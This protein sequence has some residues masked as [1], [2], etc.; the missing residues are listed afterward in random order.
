MRVLQS[1][2]VEAAMVQNVEDIKNDPQLKHRNHF[3]PLP[4][5]EMGEVLYAASAF[6]LSEIPVAMHRSGPCLGEHNYLFYKEMLGLSG[7][8]FISFL[9]EGA[10]T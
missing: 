2:G 3:L 7:E 6:R 5:S 10:F 4:H 8:E 9:N 1:A